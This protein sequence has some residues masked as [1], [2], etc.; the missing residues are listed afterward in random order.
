M[1]SDEEL[2]KL[3]QWF[4]TMYLSELLWLFADP[5]QAAN[6][7]EDYKQAVYNYILNNYSRNDSKPT[8]L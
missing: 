7:K 4:G 6:N 8:Q 3:H 5:W 1:L 2:T